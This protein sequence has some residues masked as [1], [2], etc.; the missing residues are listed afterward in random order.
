MDLNDVITVGT[1]KAVTIDGTKGEVSG[2]SNKEWTDDHDYTD[3]SK[4][5]TESQVY[6]AMKKA[7]ETAES[8]DTDTHIQKG[9]YSC[10]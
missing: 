4:A 10:R 2:L 9:A 8:H 3:S 7:Q 6:Q 1:T 5:A